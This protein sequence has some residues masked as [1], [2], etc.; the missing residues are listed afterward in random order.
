MVNILI[1]LCLAAYFILSL[2]LFWISW[3]YFPQI[4]GSGLSRNPVFLCSTDSSGPPESQAMTM[5]PIYIASTGTIPKCSFSGVYN[6]ML[7]FSRS[8]SLWS[9]EIDLRNTTW[10]YTP[11]SFA[12][13]LS[14]S[15]C[16]TFSSTLGSQPP[17]ITRVALIPDLAK[18]LM[19][20][21]MFFLRSYRFR[22]V[23]IVS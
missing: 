17:A 9:F 3:I 16:L 22:E 23:I 21:G 19:A 5:H 15:S 20:R 10:S 11:I 7:V 18:A 6:K 2:S 8:S 1:T 14:S 12:I 4:S 13:Y